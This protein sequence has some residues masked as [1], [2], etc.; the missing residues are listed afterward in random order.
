MLT[1]STLFG[2]DSSILQETDF[3]LLLLATL[4]PVLGAALM[5]PILD[6]LI[7]PL[8]ASSANIG[9]MISAYAAPAIVMIPVAGVLADRYGRKPVLITSIIIFGLGG[10]AIAFTTDFRVALALRFLQ[11]IG[12]AGINPIIITSIRDLY[13]G[14]AEATGQGIR[15]MTSG[16][17]G[18]VFPAIAGVLVIFAWQFPFLLYAVSF[19]IAI[20][21]YIWFE[22][23]TTPTR[24]TATDGGTR[25]SYI[26]ALA[27]LGTHRRVFSILVARMLWITIW[28]GFITYNSIIVIRLIDGTPLEA[29]ILTTIGFLTFSVS[30]S[31]AGR[32]TS[33]LES[34]LT[35][36]LGANFC[37]GAGFIVFLFAPNIAVAGIG[38]MI[39]GFGFGIPGALYRSIISGYAPAE[40]RAGLVSLSEAGGRLAATVTPLAMGGVISLASPAL[41][42]ST[43][44]QLAGVVV[45]VVG[46]GGSF[47][48][49]LIANVSPSVPIG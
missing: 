17:S 15:F 44:M 2:D 31:Q 3:Q 49:L 12:F 39:L 14:G 6:S 41:G 21:V 30:A 38:V 33:M 16:L 48:C 46:V 27:R 34:R 43:A 42:F 4:V 36:L 18:A 35:L 28:I 5:S 23:P 1:F 29:G 20:S 45:A 7:R 9:L 11:G 13:A 26:R 47:I 40:L 25:A 22:E 32:A 24:S 10:T 37:L 19:P 8:G